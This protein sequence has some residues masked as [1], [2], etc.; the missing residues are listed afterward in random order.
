MGHLKQTKISN[1]WL[2]GAVLEGLGA[3]SGGLGSIFKRLSGSLGERFGRG[4][5]LLERL[6]EP[7]GSHL[8]CPIHLYLV[9]HWIL[10]HFWDGFGSKSG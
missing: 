2:F 6:R 5:D 8:M 10:V 7:L 9:F 1:V 3:V 4:F